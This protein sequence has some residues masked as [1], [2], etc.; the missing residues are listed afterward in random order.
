VWEIQ[1]FGNGIQARAIAAVAAHPLAVGDAH[2]RFGTRPQI[3]DT[4]PF[5]AYARS[6]VDRI[7]GYDESLLTNEDYEFNTRIRAIGGRIWLDPAIRTVYFARPDRANTGAMAIGKRAC[8]AGIR[9]VC[10]GVRLF[11]RSSL[12]R[13]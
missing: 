8:C 3:T 10:V 13:S 12:P 5:G 4:V 1:P 9:R 6:L 7:G 2:Y 11:R